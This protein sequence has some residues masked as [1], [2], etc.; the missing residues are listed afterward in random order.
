MRLKQGLI[1]PLESSGP[2]EPFLVELLSEEEPS[3]DPKMESLGTARQAEDFQPP[4]GDPAG[5]T[6]ALPLEY[7]SQGL[8]NPMEEEDQG[9]GGWGDFTG[10][11]SEVR[12]GCGLLSP[13]E[14]KV[15]DSTAPPQALVPLSLTLLDTVVVTRN[16]AEGC[17]FSAST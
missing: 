8:L 14:V 6:T 7:N 1:E 2:A 4:K 16:S 15:G 9:Q 12:A 11:S 3:A 5:S 17:S 13:N 10:V